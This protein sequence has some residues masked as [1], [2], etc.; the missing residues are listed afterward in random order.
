MIELIKITRNFSDRS[1]KLTTIFI[2]PEHVTAIE[3]DENLQNTFEKHPE[4]FPDG[5]NKELGF[6][7]LTIS[8]GS[9]SSQYTI[10]GLP[11]VVI[12]KMYKKRTLLNG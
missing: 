11:Q 8:N 5:L 3:E 12:D 9:T 2:N 4:E 10:V 1:H 7:R 6:S